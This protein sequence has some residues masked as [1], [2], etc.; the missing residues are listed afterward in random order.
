[1]DEIFVFHVSQKKQNEDASDWGTQWTLNM[2]FMREH[3]A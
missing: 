2:T 1:M 3:N